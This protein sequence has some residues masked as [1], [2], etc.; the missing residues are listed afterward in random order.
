MVKCVVC[1]KF[2]GPKE[3]V[4]CPKCKSRSHNDC[5]RV[6]VGVMVDYSWRCGDCQSKI[7][8]E[9]DP[10]TPDSMSTFFEEMRELRSDL[11]AAR[12]NFNERLDAFDARLLA[13]EI[14]RDDPIKSVETSSLEQAL[15][16]VKL[17]LNEREQEY[18]LNDVV[19]T[20]FP[21]QKGENPVHLASLLG[22][23][24]GLTLDER[25]IVLVER[26]GAPRR[27][28]DDSS[29]PVRARRIVVRFARRITRD[30]YLQSARV[31]RGLT[32]TELSVEGAPARIY[33]NER[34]TKFNGQVFAKAREECRVHMWKYCWSKE[35][36]IYVRKEH[37]T[38]YSRVRNEAD[39][40]RIFGKTCV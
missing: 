22:V 2:L 16:D 25:D 10:S 40:G 39:L 30:E 26:E 1:G 12:S 3:G 24:M 13:L 29:A 5:V 8:K 21:E 6:P 4:G 15:V 38:P 20:G 14:A 23:K 19:I 35:G 31:R 34:L 11:S 37:G 27:A 9:R 33:V 28:P 7:P 18:L 36:R 32:T 17:Q